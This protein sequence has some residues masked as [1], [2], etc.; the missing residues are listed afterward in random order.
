MN[1]FLQTGLFLLMA[2]TPLGAL[3]DDTNLS[4]EESPQIEI[5]GEEPGDANYLPGALIDRR[6]GDRIRLLCMNSACDEVVPVLL[7]SSGVILKQGIENLKLTAVNRRVMS[8][9]SSLYP[10]MFTV[11]TLGIVALD[12]SAAPI[13][14]LLP[15]ALV[16]DALLLPA[17]AVSAIDVAILKSKLRKFDKKRVRINHKRFIRVIEA[18]F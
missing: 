16:V 8:E 14:I 17:D 11:A 2:A 1:R 6:T 9:F 13:L 12:S 15:V 4:L 7:N 18:L 3:A 10:M 5:V